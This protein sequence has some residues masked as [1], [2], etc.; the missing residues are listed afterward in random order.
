VPRQIFLLLPPSEGKAPGGQP[1][2]RW[3]AGQGA[4]G[5]AL[6]KQRSEIATVLA[7]R[8]GGDAALLGVKGAHLERALASNRKLR[9]SATLPAAERYTGVV[10]DHLDLASL[11]VSQRR[12]AVDHIIVVS[13]LM[14]WH[15]NVSTAINSHCRQHIV[16]DLLPNEHR[17]AFV[18]N[19]ELLHLYAR[20]DLMTPTGKAGGHDAKAA[21]GQLARHLLINAKAIDDA[22][23]LNAVLRKFAHQHYRCVTNVN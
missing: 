8:N 13:G 4:F 5:K 9:G 10:W 16:I 2:T 21:K 6:G 3:A 14:G 20:A 17:A 19:E 11:S 23:S 22:K 15:D 7:E 12:A 1:S 18:A